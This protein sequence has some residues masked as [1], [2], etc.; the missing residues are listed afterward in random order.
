[1]ANHNQYYVF[2]N[3]IE[4]ILSNYK[5]WEILDIRDKFGFFSDIKEIKNINKDLSTAIAIVRRII[6]T[7]GKFFIFSYV[8][9]AL[10]KAVDGDVDYLITIIVGFLYFS[11]GY[12]F[13]KI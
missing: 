12:Y 5:K 10:I 3:E 9:L 4:Y 8:F 7:V 13:L 11:I 2:G 6:K 1:M